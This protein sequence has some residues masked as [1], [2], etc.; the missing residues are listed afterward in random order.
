MNP[1]CKSHLEGAEGVVD[2]AANDEGHVEAGQ[3]EQQLVEDVAQLGP[4]SAIG[5]LRVSPKCIRA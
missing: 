3:R 1:S 4:V 2:S 5:P